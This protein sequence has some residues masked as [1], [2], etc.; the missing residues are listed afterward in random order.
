[1]KEKHLISSASLVYII[2]PRRSNVKPKSALGLRG[3]SGIGHGAAEGACIIGEGLL[4]GRYQGIVD[5]LELRG[6][7]GT[8]YDYI[9]LKGVRLEEP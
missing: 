7:R 4:G 5:S 3:A 6:A 8:I 1:M 9:R 2:T